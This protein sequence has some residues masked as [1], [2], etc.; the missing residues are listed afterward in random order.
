MPRPRK[1]LSLDD[2]RET[3]LATIAAARANG[4]TKTIVDAVSEL[5]QLA[6]AELRVVPET[7]DRSGALR[8]F[9]DAEIRAE[10]ERRELGDTLHVT[11]DL[12]PAAL[13]EMKG[14]H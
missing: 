2:L 8:L 1:K 7:G 11:F 4:Q 9:T 6:L 10:F 3:L 13:A 12:P 14:G 5:R